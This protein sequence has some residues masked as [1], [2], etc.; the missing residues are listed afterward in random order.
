MTSK[1][2]A[3]K[4]IN[5]VNLI[6][7]EEEDPTEVLALHERLGEGSYGSVYKATHLE[8]RTKVAVKQ[9]QLGFCFDDLDVDDVVKEICV[10]Q[11]LSSPFIVRYFGSYYHKDLLWIVMEYMCAGSLGD[12]MR[13]RKRVLNEDECSIVMQDCLHGL[14]YLHARHKIHRDIKAC[15]ILIGSDGIA[16]L[17]DFGV[18]GE[19]SEEVSK[20]NTV[21]GNDM[22][23]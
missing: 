18:A 2:N 6:L 21:I 4:N 17:A 20:R 5:E 1:K 10:M 23:I 22:F 9:V 13:M 3:Q 19:L 12:I 7:N 8:T 16:K 14:Q 15:N 11:E